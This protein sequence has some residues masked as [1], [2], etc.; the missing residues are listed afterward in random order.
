[1]DPAYSPAHLYLGWAY[2]Q[3]GMFEEA[4]AEMRQFH[5]LRGNAEAL[6]ALA[7]SLALSG[8]RDEAL[9]SLREMEAAVRRPGIIVDPIAFAYLHLGL[10]DTDEV[11]AWLSRALDY[12]SSDMTHVKAHPMFDPLRADERFQELLRRMGLEP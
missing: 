4:V 7:R 8:R 11:I 10:G 3:K 9:A 12:R 5:L 6:G 2:E 1:M